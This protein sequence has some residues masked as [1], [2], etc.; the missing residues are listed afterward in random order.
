MYIH[1]HIYMYYI[2]IYILQYFIYKLIMI[3]IV[4]HIIF[5]FSHLRLISPKQST[6][7]SLTGVLLMPLIFLKKNDFFTGAIHKLS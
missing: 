5:Y 7:P 2:Y 4:H 6:Q 1:I 3:K